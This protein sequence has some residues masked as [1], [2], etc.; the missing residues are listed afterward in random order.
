[1]PGEKK[2]LFSVLLLYIKYLQAFLNVILAAAKIIGTT[3]EGT[4]QRPDTPNEQKPNN[5]EADTAQKKRP[6]ESGELPKGLC[7]S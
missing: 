7:K 6:P 4:I 3:P 2:S 1:M 5:K